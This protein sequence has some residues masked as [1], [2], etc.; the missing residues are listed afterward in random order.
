MD[1]QAHLCEVQRTPK[2]HLCRSGGDRLEAI[3]PPAWRRDLADYVLIREKSAE[4]IV[5]EG[6]EPVSKAGGLTKPM[7]D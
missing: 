2:A 1:E 4:V 5:V 3:Y 7:K 6:N